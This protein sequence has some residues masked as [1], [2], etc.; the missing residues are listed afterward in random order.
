M[1]LADIQE[2]NLAKLEEHLA[3]VA[4]AHPMRVLGEELQFLSDGFEARGICHLLLDLDVEAF[5]RNLQRSAH[6]RRFF[7][8]KSREQSSTDTLFCAL[9]RTDALFDAIAGGVWALVPEIHALSRPDWVRDGE[10]EEDHCY[11][12]VVHAY[13]AGTRGAGNPA[14]AASWLARLETTV[15]AISNSALDAA[16][17]GVCT[18]FLDGDAGAFWQAFATLVDASADRA[19]ATPL[20]DGRVYEFPWLEASR[21]VS[22]ELLAWVALA[23]SRGFEPPQ[24][25]YA[26]CPSVAWSA[27]GASEASDLF[28]RLESQFAL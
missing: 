14:E 11:H 2:L 21:H 13:V 12:Q 19:A 10:Y 8:R 1:Q 9:S 16:R 25:E 4:A 6:A 27:T 20:D 3:I 23:R 26:R 28:L 7:L 17:L 24:R 22:V 15:A 5:A 18:T